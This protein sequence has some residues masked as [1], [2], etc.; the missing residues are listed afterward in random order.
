MQNA[1]QIFMVMVWA[2]LLMPA[3]AGAA[4]PLITDDSGTQ[5]AGKYQL[6]INGQHDFDKETVAGAQVK[7]SANELAAALSYGIADTVDLVVGMPYQWNRTKENG[8]T[9]FSDTGHR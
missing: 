2:V 9:T 4:H 3:S 1:R 5:G 7:T 8:V 6:E